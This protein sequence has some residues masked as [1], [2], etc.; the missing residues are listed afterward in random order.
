MQ[1]VFRNLFSAQMFF[2]KVI[3]I[4]QRPNHEKGFGF[5]ISGGREHNAPIVVDKVVRGERLLL[6]CSFW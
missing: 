3:R 1:S 5:T 2:E 4:N 6:F